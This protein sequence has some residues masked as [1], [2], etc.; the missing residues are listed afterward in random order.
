MVCAPAVALVPLVASITRCSE[1]M[2]GKMV[3]SLEVWSLTSGRN[4]SRKAN[5][6]LGVLYIFQLAAIS[7]LRICN[8]VFH[9][10]GV[11]G[12]VCLSTDKPTGL[13]VGRHWLLALLYSAGQC[14]VSIGVKP[15]SNLLAV[16][17]DYGH[18]IE[19]VLSLIDQRLGLRSQVQKADDKIFF[20][21]T[22][23]KPRCVG[24]LAI[25]RTQNGLQ[26]FV[27][28]Q[29]FASCVL[30]FS[31][32]LQRNHRKKMSI[33]VCKVVLNDL[34]PFEEGCLVIAGIKCC[35]PIRIRFVPI[36]LS[37]DICNDPIEAYISPIDVDVAALYLC[38]QCIVLCLG[39]FGAIETKC[40][41]DK[42]AAEQTEG[43]PQRFVSTMGHHR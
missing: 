40:R 7:G 5:D 41:R 15:E 32:M 38:L 19:R 18:F 42:Y 14:N 28:D 24:G 36:E 31:Q 30:L 12:R 10:H 22:Y 33:A 3:M 29:L 11:E 4:S 20:R 23:R 6:S 17:A 35:H 26:N 1:D 16:F 2:V 13:F 39:D 34:L 21:C 43:T 25:A 37:V 8:L 27:D 9:L